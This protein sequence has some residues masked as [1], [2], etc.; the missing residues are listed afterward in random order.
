MEVTQKIRCA[1]LS[2]GKYFPDLRNSRALVYTN[3]SESLCRDK[4]ALTIHAWVY[5]NLY[6][7][8]RRLVLFIIFHY[9]HAF[10][11]AYERIG[12]QMPLS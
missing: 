6:S 11:C 3:D 9:W 10:F 12:D 8:L 5:V 7:F 2:Q 4:T 1:A